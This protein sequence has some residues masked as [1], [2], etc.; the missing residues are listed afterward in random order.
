MV[1]YCEL[2]PVLIECST[3]FLSVVMM[4]RLSDSSGVRGRGVVDAITQPKVL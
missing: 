4:S 3:V 2:I 1:F